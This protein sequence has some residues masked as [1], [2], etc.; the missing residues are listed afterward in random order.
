MVKLVTVQAIC[1]HIGTAKTVTCICDHLGAANDNKTVCKYW[2]WG[3]G[4][5]DAGA[6]KTNPRVDIDIFE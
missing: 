4:H 2:L 1:N 6:F 5:I 3:Q